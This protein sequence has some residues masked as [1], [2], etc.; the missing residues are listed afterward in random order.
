MVNLYSCAQKGI[1]RN[2]KVFTNCLNHFLLNM[3]VNTE[4]CSI[5]YCFSHQNI[6]LGV[7]R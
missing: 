1:G 4:N 6:Y 2:A 5:I 3:C 7:P